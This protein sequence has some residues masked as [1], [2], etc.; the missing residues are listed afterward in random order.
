M[1]KKYKK[2]V[3]IVSLFTLFIVSNLT[4]EYLFPMDT[5]EIDIRGEITDIYVSNDV[6]TILV[7]GKIEEDTTIDKGYM[8]INGETK[9][10]QGKN[11]I[12]IEKEVLKVGDKVEAAYKGPVAE[13]YPVQGTA[14]FI[15]KKE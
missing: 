11:N 2:W 4:K 5:S 1:I 9:I 7:E 6:M 8:R 13:S 10:Y 3:I 14:K 15:I 12:L